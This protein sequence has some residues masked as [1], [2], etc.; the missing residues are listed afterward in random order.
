MPLQKGQLADNGRTIIVRL[1]SGLSWLLG[2]TLSVFNK[3]VQTLTILTLTSIIIIIF[4][5]LDCSLSTLLPAFVIQFNLIDLRQHPVEQ[6]VF[7][8]IDSNEANLACFVCR[9]CCYLDQCGI[10]IITMS[11]I[12][13]IGWCDGTMNDACLQLDV[14]CNQCVRVQCKLYT[15]QQWLLFY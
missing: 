8:W 6:S 3:H 14:A 7:N 13:L 5:I 12:S 11:K 1:K 15:V 10:S 2:D 9:V 4:Q